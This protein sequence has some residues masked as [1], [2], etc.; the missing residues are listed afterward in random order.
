MTI[1]SASEIAKFRKILYPFAGLV[2]VEKLPFSAGDTTAGVENELQAAVIGD[3]SFVDLPLQLLNSPYYQNLQKRVARG[4][5]PASLID[6]LQTFIKSCEGVWNNS[7]VRFPFSTLHEEVKEI[8]E[9]DLLANKQQPQ[10]GKRKDYDS[11]F[12]MHNNE[13]CLRI[14]ISYLLKLSL[15]Q[16]IA[17]SEIDED[18]KRLFRSYFTFFISDNTSPEVLSFKPMLIDKGG[19]YGQAIARETGLRLMLCQLLLFYANV[20]FKLKESGQQAL[21]YMAPHVPVKQNELN[22]L[23]PD[24]FYRDLFMN[25]CLNGWDQ[26]EEKHQYM[27]L[28][29]RVLSRSHLNV[30]NKLKDANIITNNLV[31]MPNTSNASLATN[32]THI[33]L[34]S[35]ILSKAA[36]NNLLDEVTEKY[37]SDLVS[38]IMEHFLPLFAV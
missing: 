38:K 24:S 28:C 34:G 9:V 36:K 25:P 11:F 18:L 37:I 29:H 14:P 16:V 2:P 27:R 26:G 17:K 13:K 31:V 10:L 33:S 1:N 5:A 6:Q 20:T 15:A 4:D 30:V 32:G 22:S 21:I 8:V 35:T 19:N 7:W 23:I 12:I 3:A